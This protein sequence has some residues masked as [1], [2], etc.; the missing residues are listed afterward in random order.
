MKLWEN[1]YVV[2]T[3]RKQTFRTVSCIRCR[4]KKKCTQ[5]CPV[6]VFKRAHLPQTIP[7]RY[8]LRS[9]LY[10]YIYLHTCR[11]GGGGATLNELSGV[12]KNKTIVDL[13]FRPRLEN[14]S[15][16]QIYLLAY[17]VCKDILKNFLKLI[18]FATLL[19]GGGRGGGGPLLWL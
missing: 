18:F 13:Y 16:T 5:Y 2:H 10:A 8:Q 19:W 17:F 15:L 12:K 3:Q 4:L 6:P 9:H 7:T 11:G 1:M 14:H